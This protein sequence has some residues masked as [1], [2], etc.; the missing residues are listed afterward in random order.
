[1][2]KKVLITG[3]AK[4]IGAACVRMLHAEGC[5]VFLH[6][7][8]SKQSAVELSEEL[9]HKRAGSVI[10]MQADLLN[11]DDL[12]LLVAE[13][14]SVWGALDVLVNN[15]SAFYPQ[16]VGEVSEQDWDGLLGANLKAPFF[17]SQ[18][19]APL[20]K[21][22]SGCIINIIDIHAERGLKG[23]PVYSITKAGLAAM[24]KI[25]AK[26]LG[27]DIRVNGVSPG[28]VIWPEAE[29]SAQE[30]AEIIQRVA[31][32]RTGEEE[33]IAKVVRFLIAEADYITGQI[34]SVDGGRTLFC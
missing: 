15:A 33:D 14:E 17:L 3:A 6:Y 34:I 29:V 4:R 20:L 8:S 23:Y 10:L 1:M 28:A 9:N 21:K 16:A 22:S 2:R 11:M 32:K 25:L 12:A 30:K 27:P 7:R 24:T 13:V 31:L 5:D 18:S 26:E 19:F